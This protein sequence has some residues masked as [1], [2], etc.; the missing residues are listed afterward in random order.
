MTFQS[1]GA[2]PHCPWEADIDPR[3][4]RFVVVVFVLLTTGT[5]CWPSSGGWVGHRAAND[6]SAVRQAVEDQWC[7]GWSAGQ[8]LQ[9]R[10]P[11]GCASRAAPD[12]TGDR[13][14]VTRSLPR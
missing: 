5:P 6:L 7:P 3:Q 12:S 2:P 10:L 8:V 4:G 14:S 9:R 1:G 13:S 11:D